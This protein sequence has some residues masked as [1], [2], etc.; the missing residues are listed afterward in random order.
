MPVGTPAAW[1]E[2]ADAEEVHL[3]FPASVHSSLQDVLFPDE[4]HE[5][6]R[7]GAPRHRV[8]RFEAILDWHDRFLRAD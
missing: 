8:E 6:S 7:S 5:L 1:L 2:A 4:G 3:T